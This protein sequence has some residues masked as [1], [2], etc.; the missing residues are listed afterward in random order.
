M[1]GSSR[2]QISIHTSSISNTWGRSTGIIKISDVNQNNTNFGTSLGD[3]KLDF[4]IFRIAF[5]FTHAAQISQTSTERENHIKA[6]FSF[7]NFCRFPLFYDGLTIHTRQNIQK[8]CHGL[9]LQSYKKRVEFKI[10]LPSPENRAFC[11]I[12]LNYFLSS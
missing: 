11:R 1:A 6:V 8:F 3:K 4:L 10:Q 5:V 9:P 12:S 7:D 2:S